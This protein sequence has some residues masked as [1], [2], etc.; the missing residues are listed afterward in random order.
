MLPCCNAIP[1]SRY[2]RVRFPSKTKSRIFLNRANLRRS[3]AHSIRIL[4]LKIA[5]DKVSHPCYNSPDIR[6]STSASRP[7]LR[8]TSSVVPLVCQ[9][10]RD[11][12]HVLHFTIEPPAFPFP[13]RRP[14]IRLNVPRSIQRNVAPD[15]SCIPCHLRIQFARSAQ[16][17]TFI[18]NNVCTISRVCAG[19]FS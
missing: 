19:Y 17:K 1:K 9:A 14:P 2:S 12:G 3:P 4:T 7:G 13:E 11:F 8:S 15:N 18:F 5:I 10:Q 6:S 16:T